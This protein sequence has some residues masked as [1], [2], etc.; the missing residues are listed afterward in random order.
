MTKILITG[1]TGKL[2]RRVIDTLLE[3]EDP[4]GISVLARNPA[5]AEP[6][7]ARGLDVRYADY[8][9]P[10]SLPEALRGV[11]RM[12]LISASSFDDELRIRQHQA[13]VDAVSRSD[14]RFVAYTSLPRAGTTPMSVAVVH[15]ATEHAIAASD[16]SYSFLRN[17]WYLENEIE[18]IDTVQRA[19]AGHDIV[20]SARHGRTGW[21]LR[22]ELGRAAAAVLT[23]SGHEN[24][25]YELS[26][27]PKTYD[28]LAA[29]LSEILGRD[30]GV[31]HVDD[32][33]FAADLAAR[34][35]PYIDLMVPFQDELRRGLLDVESND[36]GS[37]LGRPPTPLA[38]GL[39]TLIDEYGLCP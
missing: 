14:V 13:V 8:D 33:A 17:N 25:V 18:E 28:D 22:E 6:L 7:R 29:A 11:E 35:V 24:T 34:G 26:G 20:T 2:G 16:V 38:E 3:T 19:I 9:V 27:P 37:L 30:I 15:K 32:A 21:V 4:A 23:G 10:G 36:L 5:K 1:A 31:R 39:A 12:L